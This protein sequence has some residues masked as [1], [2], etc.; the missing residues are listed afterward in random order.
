[1]SRCIRHPLTLL[2]ILFWLLAAPP[3][4]W[5][6]N[7][8]AVLQFSPSTLQV[9]TGQ[10]I[11][12]AVEIKDV[13]G[14]YGFDVTVS[15]DPAIV[16]V[17]DFDPALEG[18]QVALGLFLD[19]GFVIFNQARNDL[20]QLRLVMTQLNPSEGKS[21]SGNLMVI[22]F[23][24]RQAGETPLLLVAG[25][26][27]QRDGTSFVPQ[28][29]D[30][31]LA[32]ISAA[33]P[34]QTPTP[35]PA[36]LAGTPLPTTAPDLLPAAPQA[37]PTAV[38]PPGATPQATAT[39]TPAVTQQAALA[40]VTTA[41]LSAN[42]PTPEAPAS[43]VA[44]GADGAVNTAEV[45]S[46]AA[47]ATAVPTETATPIADTTPEAVAALSLAEGA[48]AVAKGP[49][50]AVA[51]IGSGV[52]SDNGADTPDSAQNSG[53][54]PLSQVFFSAIS[55]LL[56]IVLVFSFLSRKRQAQP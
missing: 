13:T 30:G 56:I 28:L 39:A 20:G 25:E 50:A 46:T 16:E 49:A 10:T 52:G 41:P 1:M 23:R 55:L 53:Q 19:P 40:T 4:V 51:V 3:S 2:L 32:V 44:T 21:G 27:A 15:Y 29:I 7:T 24:A 37:T 48:T 38:T 11:D 43:A 31:Q 9:A 18:D 8:E 17:V 22:R 35:I 47:A 33:P 14:L 54:I 5:G 12:V 34:P 6:Q 45:E 36:Q 26:L 42:S